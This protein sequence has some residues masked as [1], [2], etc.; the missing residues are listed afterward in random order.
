M[1]RKATVADKVVGKGAAALMAEGGISVLHAIVVSTPALAL[2]RSRRIKVHYQM[3]VPHIINRTG[4][5][6]CPVE[7]L[8]HA[9]ATPEDCVQLITTFMTQIRQ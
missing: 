3:E 1:L 7:K 5:D 9:C 4:D 8:C 6:I 2:L